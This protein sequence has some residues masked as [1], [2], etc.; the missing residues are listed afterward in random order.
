M[1]QDDPKG[2]PE[3]GLK[4][5]EAGL[6]TLLSA[7]GD[8]VAEVTQ[9]LGDGQTGEFHRSIDIETARGPL[10]AEAGV[11]VCFADQ[12]GAAARMDPKDP[13]PQDAE[14]EAGMPEKQA[15]TTQRAASF[16]VDDTDGVWRAAV[17]LPGAGPDALK[18]SERDGHA[19]VETT[20]ARQYRAEVPLPPTVR[21]VDLAVMLRNGVLELSVTKDEAR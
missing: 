13:E 7:L 10:R 11:R 19:I 2:P 5:I 14:A 16:E 20:G 6:G 4:A 12:V 18:L 1:T 9:R 21:V 17:D 8:A 15:P 3:P